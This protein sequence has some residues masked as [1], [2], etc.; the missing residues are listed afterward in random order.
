MISTK[1]ITAPALLLALTC[2]QESVSFSDLH[3]CLDVDADHLVYFSERRRWR[4]EGG[5]IDDG[6]F[7]FAEWEV[8]MGIRAVNYCINENNNTYRSMQ[9]MVGH[10]GT[11]LDDWIPL[12]LHGA[13]GGACRRW[14]I[15]D[16]DY[17]RNV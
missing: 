1:M 6:K 17:I 4:K 14:V 5:W 8:G 2:A 3:E 7:L 15:D 16:E 9:L 10:E 12:A 11:T 13:D